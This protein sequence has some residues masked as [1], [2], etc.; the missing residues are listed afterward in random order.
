MVSEPLLVNGR[1]APWRRALAASQR[2]DLGGGRSVSD[3]AVDVALFVFAAGLGVLALG[4]A[5]HSHGAVL[6]DFDVA[7][8]VL[9]C[10]ALWARRGDQDRRSAPSLTTAWP[11]S[12]LT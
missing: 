12:A 11:R 4:Y 10:L 8:G 3:W 5:W 1:L 2:H 7:F 6:D 9:A